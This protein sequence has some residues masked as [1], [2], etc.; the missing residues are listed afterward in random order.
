MTDE[1]DELADLLLYKGDVEAEIQQASR[2][3]D[4][5]E[6]ELSYWEEQRWQAETNLENAEEDLVGVE[7]KILEL[8]GRVP[9][10]TDPDQTSL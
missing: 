2:E 5:A 3:L 8:Q 1:S 7:A 6:E 10:S 4:N 9:D